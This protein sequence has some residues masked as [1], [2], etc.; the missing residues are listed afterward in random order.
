MYSFKCKGKNPY[1]K[2]IL[3]EKM[4][5]SFYK[6]MMAIGIPIA[7]QNLISASLNMVDTM[8]ITRVSEEAVAAVGL[9]NQLFFLLVLEP[10]RSAYC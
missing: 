5:K 8:M 1:I 6:A 4:K 3:G 9:A 10:S 7:L 2:K